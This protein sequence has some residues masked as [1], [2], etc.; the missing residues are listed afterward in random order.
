D[1]YSELVTCFTNTI[2]NRDGGTH[3]TGFRQSLTRTVNKYAEENKLLKD[4]KGGLSGEDLREGIT[5]VV[6]VKVAD[7]KYS[8][9]AK[10]KL[11]S[12]EVSAAVSAV[13]TE[14]LGQYLEQQP[15]EARTI[16]GKAILASRAREAARKA[17]EMV[18]RK[19][20]L[21]LSSLPG[22]LAD[23]QE[24]DPE[25]SELFIVEGESAGGSAKQGRSRQFQAILPLKGKILN[26]EKV[27]FDRMLASQELTTLI[28]ALGTSVGEEKDMTKLRYHK[29][30]LMTDADVDGSHIR[31]LLLTFF[32]RHFNEMF[33]AGHV[34]IAQPPLYKVKK[35]KT[36]LYLK[37]EQSL[38]DFL[39]DSSTKETTLHLGNGS[40]VSGKAL[41][42][43]VK[44][45]TTARRLRMQL[46]KRSDRRIVSE[47][48]DAQL[49][50]SDLRDRDKLERIEAK[51]MAEVQRRHGELGQAGAE[52]KEDTEHG[53]WE[54]RFAAGQHGVRRQTTISA[55][56]VRSPEF[57]ELKRI[58][59]ELKAKLVEPLK[60]SHDGGQPQEIKGWDEIASQVEAAGKKGLQIQRY[61][62]LGEMNAEQLW[63]TTMDPERRNLLKVKVEDL[64]EADG[65]FTKLMGDLVEPRREFIEENALNVRNLDV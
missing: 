4:A 20:A 61:K 40:T 59:A 49:S 42:D 52:Y 14:K 55:E 35:G 36:E 13:V 44:R 30:I 5:A 27:R 37:N 2:K 33:E 9:Q 45:I 57:N 28:T 60:L 22:K 17:R 56:L 43:V 24:R 19:G 53:T 15:K 63:E 23:C 11:V 32:F 7:P 16:I 58:S 21:E 50:E 65:I 39:L 6:S 62:G 38:E 29:I 31:T 51:V 18:Q 41:A 34:Y 26:V 12:S 10:D 8:N 46:D 47:F 64:E 1:G 54:L 25:K 48:A 3:L